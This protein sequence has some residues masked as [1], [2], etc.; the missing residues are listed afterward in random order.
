MRIKRVNKLEPRKVCTETGKVS[1]HTHILGRFGP[2]GKRTDCI[3]YFSVQQ[4][5]EI[6]HEASL[7]G[8]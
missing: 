5:R 1:F 2:S 4:A 8:L 3:C 6:P 7:K